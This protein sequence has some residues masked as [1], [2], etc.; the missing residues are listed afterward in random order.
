MGNKLLING[1]I[2]TGRTDIQSWT[3][4]QQSAG[5]RV[6]WGGGIVDTLS[7]ETWTIQTLY[8]YCIGPLRRWNATAFLTR[9]IKA[10]KTGP[11]TVTVNTT[12]DSVNPPTYASYG[13]NFRP[14]GL[15]D[16]IVEVYANR[17]GKRNTTPSNTSGTPWYNLN[18]TTSGVCDPNSFLG[19]VTQ[20]YTQ[21]R[22]TQAITGAGC[23]FSTTG[24][25][26]QAGNTTPIGY[27]VVTDTGAVASRNIT[28]QP[29]VSL[30]SGDCSLIITYTDGKTQTLTYPTCPTVALIEDELCPQTCSIANQII[31]TLGG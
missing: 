30:A 11:T 19:R 14:S 3:T 24:T 25:I 6:D 21:D 1:S 22:N 23:T 17:T 28:P 27:R 29:S 4:Q 2:F 15:T 18:Y 10:G 9:T 12:F 5:I 20:V 16:Y 7:G 31:S 8:D 13:V 26:V